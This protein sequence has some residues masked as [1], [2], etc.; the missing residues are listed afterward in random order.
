MIIRIVSDT[1]PIKQYYTMPSLET[2]QSNMDADFNANISRIHV[3]PKG[4][5]SIDEDLNL[6]SCALMGQGYSGV[7][8][9]TVRRGTV[10][11][12]ADDVSVNLGSF[13]RM[14]NLLIDHS[15]T[16]TK[17]AITSDVNT[18]WVQLKDIA[19]HG[20]NPDVWAL[21]PTNPYEWY[22]EGVLL[23]CWGNG[24]EFG[25]HDDNSNTGDMLFNGLHI[26]LHEGDV[27]GIKAD[28]TTPD[29]YINDIQF[30]DLY[31]SGGWVTD[32]E[33][34]NVTGID[35]TNVKRFV[36][37][38]SNLEE[39]STGLKLLGAQHD[40]I[41]HTAGINFYGGMIHQNVDI[42][43]GVMDATFVNTQLEGV[44]SDPY[45]AGI[46]INCRNHWLENSVNYYVTQDT[47]TRT[48]IYAGVNKLAATQQTAEPTI[49]GLKTSAASAT[50]AQDNTVAYMGSASCKSTCTRSTLGNFSISTPTSIND[51]F[52]MV[53]VNPNKMH[54]FSVYGKASKVTPGDVAIFWYDDQGVLIPD[55]SA[56]TGINLYTGFNYFKC[57]GKSP[58]DAAYAYC[59]LKFMNGIS[60]DALWWDEAWLIQ[61]D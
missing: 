47:Y 2:L 28:V 29:R 50:I 34:E 27:T 59:E 51:T 18:F 58:A 24:L 48:P 6:K 16:A 15:T 41:V 57:Q 52:G 1:I 23:D 37:V 39:C 3:L 4:T 26:R 21:N 54:T 19:V 8:T 11:D 10:L 53:S 56:Y 45:N 40:S 44:V 22:V 42:G 43:E 14:E 38:K 12:L 17:N 46:F 49:D 55:Y 13:G 30:N 33:T 5:L 36:F 25:W 61:V 32:W 20:G 60:G 35:L 9:N 31:V 7:L